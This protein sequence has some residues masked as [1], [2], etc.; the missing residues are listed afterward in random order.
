MSLMRRYIYFI[1]VLV[2]P[3]LVRSQHYQF[4]QFYAAPTYLNPAFT[5]A[6]VCSRVSLNYRSQWSGIPGTFT[7]YLASYDHYVKSIKSGIGLQFFSDMAGLGGLRTTQVSLL[8]AYETR[9]NKKLMGRGGIS[10][11]NIQ[12]RVD[13]SAFTFG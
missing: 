11:G 12:R 10:I 4:S 6:N 1:T 9:L 5:G 7:S 2:M 3:G 8:Y 13:Y